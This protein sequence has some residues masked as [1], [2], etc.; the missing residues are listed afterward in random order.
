MFAHRSGVS[1]AQ[2]FWL[3]AGSLQLMHR[4]RSYLEEQRA[5]TWD[6]E[7]INTAGPEGIVWGLL[8]LR[9]ILCCLKPVPGATMYLQRHSGQESSGL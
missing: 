7:I 8:Q 9:S 2:E 4:L 6:S 3:R 1:V 5:E